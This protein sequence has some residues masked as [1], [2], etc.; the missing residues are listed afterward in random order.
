MSRVSVVPDSARVGAV[1]GRVGRP[2]APNCATVG[3]VTMLHFAS[4]LVS[5]IPL[6]LALGCAT[7]PSSPVM[8][9]PANLA[10]PPPAPTSDSQD[11]DAWSVDDPGGPTSEVTIDTRT[12]TW[13]SLD[14]APD[15]SEIV[16]DLLGDLYVLPFE[17]GEARPLS[18]GIAW[19]MQPRYSP[20]GRHIAFTSDRGGGDNIWVMDR[21]GS[22]ARA[23]SEED[24]RL[25]NSPVWS[26]DGRYVA[27][28]KHYSSRRSL[29]S[30]EIWLYHVSG[31]K[32]VQLNEK[33]N[34]QKDLGE[35]AFSPDGRYVYYSRDTTPGGVFEYSRDPYGPIYEIL[36]LDRQEGRTETFVSEAGGSVRPTPSPDGR[37][38]AFVRRVQG[39]SVLFVRDLETGGQWPVY[40]GLDHDMQET[41]AIHGVYPTIAW[42]PDARWIVF[43][44]GGTLHRVDVHSGQRVDIPFHVQGT[45]TVA[46]SLRFPVEV[47]PAEFDVKLLRWVEVSPDASQVAYQALGYVFLRDQASGDV[48]RLTAQAEHFEFYPTFSRD[49]KQLALTTWHDEQLGSVRVVDI[50]TGKERI[51]TPEPGHYV[52]PA[53]SPDGRHLVFRRV[54][55]AGTRSQRHAHETGIYVVDLGKGR[56]S[57]GAPRRL[58]R[59]GHD[60]QFGEDPERVFFVSS[61]DDD[62]R[63]LESIA[64][65]GIERRAHVESKMATEM[66]VSPDGRHL[67]FAEGFHT[68]V[69]LFP[70]TGR[71]IDLGPKDEQLPVAKISRDAGYF[72]HWSGDGSKVH[73]SLGPNLYTRALTDAFAFLEGAPATLPPPVTEGQNIGFRHAQ[74]TPTGAVALVGGKVVTMRGDEVIA[75]GTVVF[76]ENR[77]V[78]VGPRASVVV[79]PDAHVVDVVGHTVIPGLVDV[80]AHGSQGSHGITPQNNWLHEATLAFG[81]TTVH[82]PSNDT[83]QIFAA[84]ELAR[85]GLITAPRI[86]STGT[87]LYGAKG[88][89]RANVDSLDDARSH[90]RRLQAVG[91]FSVKSYNQPRREQRQQII[92]AARELG[93]MV[94]PEGGS[95]YQHNMTMVVDGHTGIEHSLPVARVYDDVIQLWGGTEV[96]Y[97]PTLV[98]SYGGVMGEHYWYQNTNVYD[99]AKLRRFVPPDRVAGRAHRGLH[100]SDEDWHHI[101][102]AAAAKR[103]RDAGVRANVGAHGQREGLAAHWEMWMLAQG[104]FTPLEALR[105]GTLDGA[106]YIGLDHDLGSI[107]VGKLADLAVIAGDPLADIRQSEHVRMTVING[108]VFDATTMAEI[109]NHPRPAAVPYWER[110]ASR[111]ER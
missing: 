53:F 27:A 62:S 59:D 64:L 7:A 32:G 66:R 20:D 106:H 55:S 93:M 42:T 35:P 86:Y 31:G 104:G 10:L 54:G 15:G 23:I 12:G 80:H 109:G 90:L 97:T 74:P 69:T 29:G 3:P 98:V 24:F 13:M 9:P 71:K 87:I 107:E 73:W 110:D 21:D 92:A 5:I 39:K 91:A 75:D 89:F 16:F 67:A 70:A 18:T 72:L 76:R 19:D 58:I 81:V 47:A 88:D 52:E 22:D 102:V 56:A 85:A 83:L 101:D 63:V 49:G 30:G 33:P 45:R 108:R 68:Y 105:A 95:L 25:L 46:P 11:E 78:A 34:E 84:S 40:D 2:S 96:G 61:G 50:G 57:D 79:P 100:V 36:R 82:D 51:V 43:W 77:I 38:F 60:A 48:R 65:T 6:A 44:A 17:G 26:P 99:H 8:P 103:L 14:V 4:R 37:Y 111:S 41:W 1:G 94:V 28:R